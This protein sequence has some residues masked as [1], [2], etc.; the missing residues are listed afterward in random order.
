MGVSVLRSMAPMAAQVATW[1]P[2]RQGCLP[3]DAQAQSFFECGRRMLERAAVRDRRVRQ[4]ERARI[5]PV[6]KRATRGRVVCDVAVE[7]ARESAFECLVVRLTTNADG[8]STS[9]DGVNNAHDSVG[10]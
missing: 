3:A 5:R 4:P 1:R 7:R 2:R 10:A 8:G 6:R 9:L